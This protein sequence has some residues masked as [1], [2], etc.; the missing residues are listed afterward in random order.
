MLTSGATSSHMRCSLWCDL[1]RWIP[2]YSS[3]PS[4]QAWLWACLWFQL[5][6]VVS[7]CVALHTNPKLAQV[8][9]ARAKKGF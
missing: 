7:T 5:A 1:L 2:S 9:L 4:V 8:K 6:A 3:Y